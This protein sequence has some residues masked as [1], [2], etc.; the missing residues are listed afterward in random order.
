MEPPPRLTEGFR[1]PGAT[2]KGHDH[3]RQEA[4]EEDHPQEEWAQG[5]HDQE[6]HG[7]GAQAPDQEVGL[8]GAA[9][10][11]KWPGD[12]RFEHS[13]REAR[14]RVAEASRCD[15]A[16]RGARDGAPHALGAVRGLPNFGRRVR[17]G[18]AVELS[19]RQAHV[20][21]GRLEASGAHPRDAPRRHAELQ[22]GR[23]RLPRARQARLVRREALTQRVL[24]VER[25]HDAVEVVEH[26]DLD[27]TLA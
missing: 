24:D 26:G 18:H 21:R 12:H 5:D 2:A 27:G 11:W 4:F 19:G 25:G 9:S 17:R 14:R 13:D 23:R 16:L 7:P 22:E 20:V 3:G 8:G 15:R 6:V 10:R 1:R